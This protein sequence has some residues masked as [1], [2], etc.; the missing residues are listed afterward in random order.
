MLKKLSVIFISC[1][2]LIQGTWTQTS[3]PTD[4][5]RAPIDIEIFLSGNFGELRSNHFHAGIDIKTQGIIGHKVYSCADGY[6]SRIKVEAA[7]YGNTL[8]ITH[9]GGYTTVYAHLNRFR[10][11][12]SD[13]VRQ[14]QYANQQHAI[15]LFPGKEEF[16]VS[17]GDMVAF[18]GT[19]GYSFGPHLH[20][21]I[22][23]AANQEPLNAMKFGLEIKDI[24]PPRIFSLY[25]Y[26]AKEN[27]IANHSLKKTRIEVIGENGNYR[28]E[29]PDTV[30]VNGKIGFG[31]EAFDYLNGA[32]NRCGIYR[33]RVLVDSAMK[34]HWEMNR[35][36]FSKARYVNS[37]IDYE[38]RSRNNKVVQKIFIDPNN[39]LDLYKYV[40]D[41][42]M[43]DFS[44]P[45]PY[46]VKFILEDAYENRS[47][48]EFIVQGGSPEQIPENDQSPE[49][50]ED[51]V[52]IMKFSWS[53]ANELRK[54]DII[55]SMPE[56]ALYDNLNFR[57]HTLEQKA[58]AYSPVHCLHNPHTPVQLASELKI[59][60]LGLP[61]E[62]KDKA[63]IVTLDDDNEISAAGGE[64][65]DGFISTS[66]REFGDYFIITDTIAPEIR[67]MDLKAS[68]DTLKS[69]SVRFKV[70]DK[71]SGIKSYEGYIDNEW[72][73]F[74][75]DLKNDMVFYRFDP[76]RL[77][78][79]KHHELELY[80]IDNKENIAYYYA[81]F[82]W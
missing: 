27:S 63:L 70:S 44:E 53:E 28:L 34:Y 48:L 19:S 61:E 21:E 35:F 30:S 42:G 37:Y 68:T 73:L 80:I 25:L 81:E 52:R 60:P 13:F 18:S 47:E 76:S 74:E 33:I 11:D 20:F 66:I 54:E 3:F 45:R 32:R 31:I 24:I 50:E 2:S 46:H 22:R 38:E 39:T 29:N 9:P 12:I 79:G 62:L 6:I 67:S 15:N 8:Y 1:F 58:G 16:P 82:N 40:E 49:K 43:L 4:Y 23:D 65:K 26:P 75:Y 5:F 7:G 55:F 41:D 17:K 56:G 10:K 51:N 77:Q 71:I 14:K 69:S 78:S 59:R 57:Y 64:W 72:V 36:P